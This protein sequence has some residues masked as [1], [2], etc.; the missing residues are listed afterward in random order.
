M[1]F[2]VWGAA[3]FALVVPHVRRAGV[4][5]LAGAVVLWNVALMVQFGLGLMDRQRLVWRDI[6]HNQI[7]EVPPRLVSVVS[8]Y[9][10]ARDDLAGSGR[11]EPQ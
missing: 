11:G 9:F 5:T 8:R 10:V 4:A 7:Y 1:I 3:F 6:V 2:A